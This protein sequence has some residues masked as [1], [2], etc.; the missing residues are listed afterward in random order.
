M[1]QKSPMLRQI[2]SVPDLME[3]LLEPLDRQARRLASDG[4]LGTAGKAVFTGCGD[5]YCAAGVAASLFRELAGMDAEVRT[6]MDVS[7][8]MPGR[9]LVDDGGPVLLVGI[10]ASGNVTRVAECMERVRKRDGLCLAVTGSADS[11]VGRRA[12]HLLLAEVPPFDFAPGIR[13]YC[14]SLLA[15]TL[16]AVDLGEGRGALPACRAADLRRELAQLPQKLRQ[17]MPDMLEQAR[18][19]AE[20]MTDARMFEIAASGRDRYTALFCCAKLIEAVGVYTTAVDTEDWF[21]TAYFFR[22][23]D[24]TATC[25]LSAADSPAAE[26]ELELAA[27]A[28]AMG[29]RVWSVSDRPELTAAGGLAIPAG[30]SAC[31]RPLVQ[32]LPVSAAASFLCDLLGE[33]YLRG[34]RDN[35]AHCADCALIAGGEM[36]VL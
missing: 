27:E 1:E 15:L 16:L 6:A 26:R 20:G 22:D 19:A 25:L 28:A 13:S 36:T 7:R 12:T 34:G 17:A 4:A 35:W 30:V 31:L 23:L 10:S 24:H 21:H 11:P 8:H 5:S 2:E 33:T 14:A 32:Y 9:R 3:A 29:R 18:R